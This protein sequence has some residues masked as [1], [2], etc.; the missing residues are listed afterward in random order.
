MA[1][2]KKKKAIKKKDKVV[3]TPKKTK[4]VAIVG[5]STSKDLAPFKY[6]DWEIWG[7][8]NLFYHIPPLRKCDRW[9]EIH[10]ITKNNEGQFQR[11]GSSNFRGTEIN[12][13]I[14]ALGQMPCP[15]MMQ[16]VWDEIPNSEAYPL[17]EIKRRF[18]SIMGW[19]SKNDAPAGLEWDKLNPQ[20]YG[21]N[22]VTYRILLAIHLGATH[23]GVW[24]VDMAVDTEYHY[25]RPSCE[26]ALGYAMGLG[27][28][29]YVPAE[30]DLLKTI[31]LYGF[32]EKL[33]DEWLAKLNHMDGTLAEKEHKY[34]G[35]R[36]E[37]LAVISRSDGATR[38]AEHLRQVK[39]SNPE[40]VSGELMQ[41]I[42]GVLVGIKQ[43]EQAA[44]MELKKCDALLQQI[45]GTKFCKKELAK[46][47]SVLQPGE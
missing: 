9:F 40:L 15:V 30:A 28:D 14:A 3:E 45:I 46:I 19:Y 11:R 37:A 18:G 32:E 8:N 26:W 39:T 17:D 27:I 35:Q 43:Q 44:K 31:H 1:I 20:L 16:K 10:N 25:Q 36:Q 24:G 29:V 5:C 41:H 34:E 4:K 47:W 33:N 23:I 42:E 21:T 12:Q 7:V 22:T 38:L 6:Q 2:E 13:Y